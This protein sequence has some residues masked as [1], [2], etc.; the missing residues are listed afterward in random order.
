MPKLK[1][2]RYKRKYMYGDSL[3]KIDNHNEK[4][5]I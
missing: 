5:E 1:L 2:I 3:F 4:S